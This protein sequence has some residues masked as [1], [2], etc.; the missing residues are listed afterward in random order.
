MSEELMTDKNQ[1]IT[2]S[3]NKGKLGIIALI[4]VVVCSMLGGGV[5]SLPQNSAVSSAVG[6]VIIA[7]IIAGIGIYFIANS[8]RL[9]SDLRPD[10]NAGVYMYAQEGFGSFVGFNVAW[11]Y[12]LMTCLGNVAF[13]VLLM[14]AFDDFFPGVFT[15]GNNLTSIICGSILIWYED[16]H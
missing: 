14:D 1:N 10:L 4:A 6:P 9:L 3:D 2:S 5:F 15:G 12:W 8:F 16:S 13:A 11:G 7:W